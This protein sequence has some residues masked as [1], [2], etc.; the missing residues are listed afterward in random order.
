MVAAATPSQLERRATHSQTFRQATSKNNPW[1]CMALIPHLAEVSRWDPDRQRKAVVLQLFGFVSSDKITVRSSTLTSR[2]RTT[3]KM[4]AC[5]WHWVTSGLLNGC[6]SGAPLGANRTVRQQGKDNNNN[7]NKKKKN[8]DDDNRV[9]RRYSRFFTISSQ[10][11]ELSPTCTHK[12][13]GRNRVQITCN[14]SIAYHVQVSCYVPLG[15]KG[16]LSY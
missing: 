9:Q 15:T 10:R 12:W 3:R 7:N 11:R 8:D 5:C 1:C 16:Q 2:W 6:Q 4:R 13:P 14:T